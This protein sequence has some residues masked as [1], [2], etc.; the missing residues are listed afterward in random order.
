MDGLAARQ[1][2]PG[3]ALSSRRA[4]RPSLLVLN[5]EGL[6]PQLQKVLILVVALTPFLATAFAVVQVR[7]R[8]ATGPIRSR[9]VRTGLHHIYEGA[10][11]TPSGF[12][13]SQ[14]F[15]PHRK[16]LRPPGPLLC[17]TANC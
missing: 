8:P 6:E 11:S 13:L 10:A 1:L 14:P 2:S 17:P 15:S 16:P 3:P 7:L 9:S 12:A 4:Q 5:G